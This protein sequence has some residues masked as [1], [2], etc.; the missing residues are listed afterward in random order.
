[1]SL[2]QA[3]VLNKFLSSQD[4]SII[5]KAYQDFEGYFLNDEI[6]KNIWSS[7]EEQFQE[8]FMKILFVK[9]VGYTISPE[10]NY[11]LT[12]ELKN[13]PKLQED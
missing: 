9:I 4:E 1:M 10:P 11:N 2:F 3:S 8:G 12:T 7:K 13:R 6:Q 5:K